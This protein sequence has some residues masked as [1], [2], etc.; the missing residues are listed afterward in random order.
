ME[1][2]NGTIGAVSMMWLEIKNLPMDYKHPIL[3]LVGYWGIPV[4]TQ[5]LQG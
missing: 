4:L 5:G 1:D 2:P 3:H